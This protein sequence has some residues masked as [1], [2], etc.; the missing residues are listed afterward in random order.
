MLLSYP[1]AT[2]HTHTHKKKGVLLANLWNFRCLEVT[3]HPI[4]PNQKQNYRLSSTSIIMS[5]CDLGDI[6]GILACRLAVPSILRLR[7]FPKQHVEYGFLAQHMRQHMTGESLDS[8]L[9]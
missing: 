8:F 9:P 2:G 6:R 4:H 1:P 5:V 3:K 7:G